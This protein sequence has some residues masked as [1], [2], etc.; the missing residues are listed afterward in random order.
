MF[1]MTLEKSLGDPRAAQA[2]KRLKEV[3]LTLSPASR[4]LYHK[5]YEMQKILTNRAIS[6]KE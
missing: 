6:K 4:Q 1:Q 5:I 3:L 2:S